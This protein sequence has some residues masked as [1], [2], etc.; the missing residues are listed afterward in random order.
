MFV[1]INASQPWGRIAFYVGIFSLVISIVIG[2]GDAIF[3]AY[4]MD[5]SGPVYVFWR[6]LFGHAEYLMIQLI[7]V[8]ALVFV[9]AKFFEVRTIITVG[10]DRLDGAK[11]VLKGPDE[12]NVVWIGHRYGSKYEADAIAVALQNRLRESAEGKV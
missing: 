7:Y 3:Q 9:A 11:V 6:V 2:V 4:T 12:Q 5:F 8:A 10:F 1:P